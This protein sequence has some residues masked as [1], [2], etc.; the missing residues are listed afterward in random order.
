MIPD[1]LTLYEFLDSSVSILK[2]TIFIILEYILFSAF[3]YLS[4]QK[5]QFKK[6]ILYSS[7]LFISVCLTLILLKNSYYSIL[8]SVETILVILFSILFFFDQIK[9]P[10]SF[11][12]YSTF[13]FWVVIGILFYLTGTFFLFVF[14]DELSLERVVRYWI[15][16]SI[17]NIF[18][19]LFIAIG[20]LLPEPKKENNLNLNYSNISEIT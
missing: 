20:F 14:V 4:I 17:C 10:Q 7:F 15:I 8:A 18:K 19:N 9:H 5:I 3:F 16:N 2:L 11:F 12:I 1:T 6:L 13:Q